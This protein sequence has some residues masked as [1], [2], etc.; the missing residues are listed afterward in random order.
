MKHYVWIFLVLTVSSYSQIPGNGVTDIDGDQ[1]NSVII[2]TQEWQKENLNVSKYSDGTP[3]PQ[4]TNASNWASLST[5]AWCY[6]NNDP[7]NGAIYG[8]LYN[9]YAVAGIHDAASLTNP[10]LRK[11]L[12]PTGWHIPTDTEWTTIKDLLGGTNI[13]GDKMKEVGNSH[14]NGNLN[15]TNSSGFTGLPG[16]YQHYDGFTGQFYR[17]RNNGYWW[18]SS[19]INLSNVWS[20]SLDRDN[21]ILS[22]DNSLK[23]DG[24]SVRLINDIALNSHSFNKST[25]I[26]YPNPAK[27]YINIDI[28][29]LTDTNGWSYK[30]TN[31]L[32]QEV[33]NG[34]INSQQNIVQLNN[35]KGHGVYFAKMYDSSNKL[36]DTK[37]IIIQK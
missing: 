36:M 12:A 14:W 25:F 10:D 21:S 6:Y 2:G 8:K 9:W 4:V 18:S 16:G 11:K 15:A 28:S 3:I 22:M 27:D 26:I 37:K 5:G 30:I 31:T 20:V 33:I 29:N 24:F 1:Y 7:A 35:I 32:G 34:K 17:I 19:E 23:R 13:E